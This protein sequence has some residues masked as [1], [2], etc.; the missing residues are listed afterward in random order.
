MDKAD[1]LDFGELFPSA[2]G[3]F[4]Q[5]CQEL[6]PYDAFAVLQFRQVYSSL[7]ECV[8]VCRKC[9]K[10]AVDELHDGQDN[11]FGVVQPEFGK[12]EDKLGNPLVGQL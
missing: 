4:L 5:S 3:H 10:V 12:G 9:L 1:L 8:L 2:E 6:L 7:E 11:E